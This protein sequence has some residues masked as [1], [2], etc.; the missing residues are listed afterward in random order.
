MEKFLEKRASMAAIDMKRKE[1]LSDRCAQWN[2]QSSM[3]LMRSAGCCCA[4]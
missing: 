3:E 1:K 2:M 4:D